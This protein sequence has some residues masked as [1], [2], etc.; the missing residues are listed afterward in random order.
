MCQDSPLQL[1][2]PGL[3]SH[4]SR[5]G[6]S[7]CLG[8]S[9]PEHPGASDGT[10]WPA[11]STQ[12]GCLQNGSKIASPLLC[13]HHLAGVIRVGFGSLNFYLNIHFPA[14]LLE[15]SGLLLSPLKWSCLWEV[16]MALLRHPW[17]SLCSPRAPL[18]PGSLTRAGRCDSPVRSPA[19]MLWGGRP[20]CHRLLLLR[21]VLGGTAR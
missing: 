21:A 18:A 9:P 13:S 12:Q 2:L 6:G 15:S 8:R 11:S 16:L 17:P 4:P 5:A 19:G 14:E 3:G 20:G 1:W 10:L 7:R